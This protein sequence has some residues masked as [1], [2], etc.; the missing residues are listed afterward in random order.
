M[1]TIKNSVKID[2]ALEPFKKLG[3]PEDLL[4]IDIETTGFTARSSSLYLIGCAYYEA[5]RFHTIQWFADNFQEEELLLYHFF[6]FANTFKTIVHFNGN[7]FDIPYLEAKSLSYGF[8]FDFR[9]FDGVDIYK[10]LLPYKTFMKLGSMKQRSIE[11]FLGINRDDSFDGGHLISVYNEY[12][13]APSEFNLQLLLNHNYEDLRGMLRIVPA[14]AISDLFN[15][16]VKVT[17]AGRNPYRD[18]D[19][20]CKSEVI[21]ELSLPS[22]LPVAISYGFSDCYFTG[23][24]STGRLRVSIKEGELR[25]FYPN[26]KDYYYLPAEDAAIHKSVASF[27]DAGHREPAKAS[28]CYTKA[29][30]SFLPQW[31]PMFTPI[32]RENYGDATM[33]FELTDDFK[34]DSSK[35]TKYANHLLQVIAHP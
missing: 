24:G 18:M 28:N 20:I 34:K 15:D 5:D 6:N 3:N 25:L 19:G 23:E 31:D 1:Q 27:V 7:H 2:S 11:E 9:A 14:L 13:D 29:S 12:V 33:Y 4:F 30:G 16:G 10:R 17:K 8:T 22:P 35:F 32:F 21:M 26:Y